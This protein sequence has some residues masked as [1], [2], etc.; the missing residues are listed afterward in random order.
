M[1]R[2]RGCGALLP[3]LDPGFSCVWGRPSLSQRLRVLKAVLVAVLLVV[4]GTSCGGGGQ[5]GVPTDRNPAAPDATDVETTGAPLP[6]SAPA[7]DPAAQAERDAALIH[8]LALTKQ[9]KGAIDGRMADLPERIYDYGM[10]HGGVSVYETLPSGGIENTPGN[11][12]QLVR[13]TTKNV[14]VSLPSEEFYLRYLIAPDGARRPI[15]IRT[16]MSTP[17]GEVLY[18]LDVSLYE[19][20][21]PAKNYFNS[22]FFDR[23][24]YATQGP[25]GSSVLTGERCTVN[26][27]YI[28]TILAKMDRDLQR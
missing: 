24:T 6:P 16:R 10:R 22:S 17:T 18:R 7:P 8:N 27:A 23:E 19:I 20:D 28:D 12:R 15:H 13:G 1:R 2:A 11:L 3:D 26:P 14:L 25:L 5:P 4:A 9:V 21:D